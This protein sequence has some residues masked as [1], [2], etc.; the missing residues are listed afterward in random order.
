MVHGVLILEKFYACLYTHTLVYLLIFTALLY[1]V[2]IHPYRHS[3]LQLPRKNKQLPGRLTVTTC[4]VIM[5]GK[6]VLHM[7]AVSQL[8]I[9]AFTSVSIYC[10]PRL[11]YIIQAIAV[12]KYCATKQTHLCCRIVAKYIFCVILC[13]ASFLKCLF[14]FF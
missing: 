13:M 4:T 11:K 10:K 2:N 9:H 5:H 6:S 8:L 12:I 1:M 3:S 7:C 14:T